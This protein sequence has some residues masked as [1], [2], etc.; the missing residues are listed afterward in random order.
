MPILIECYPKGL[1][2][3]AFMFH[4][5]SVLVKLNFVLIA[6]IEFEQ[7]INEIL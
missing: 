7:I 6:D 4:S 5:I 2:P 1:Q 3:D